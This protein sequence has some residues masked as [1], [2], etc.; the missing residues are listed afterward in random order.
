MVM[1]EADLNGSKFKVPLLLDT[2]NPSS[3]D[4]GAQHKRWVSIQKFTVLCISLRKIFDRR[5]HIFQKHWK[6]MLSK[7]QRASISE[8]VYNIAPM[9]IYFFL[10]LSPPKRCFFLY[11]SERYTWKNSLFSPR[12]WIGSCFSVFTGDMGRSDAQSLQQGH[13][14]WC[15]G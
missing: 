13:L 14:W 8:E 7:T 12:S 5:I 10:A 1:F 15:N 6:T 4:L 2:D 11:L 3:R 9:I